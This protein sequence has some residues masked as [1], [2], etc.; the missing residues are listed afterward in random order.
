M[1]AGA[2]PQA[3]ALVDVLVDEAQ[4][5]LKGLAGAA[6]AL[7]G[8]LAGLPLHVGCCNAR[9]VEMSQEAEHLL[10]LHMCQ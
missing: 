3:S 1:L 4:G 2:A 6:P 7:D 10:Q 9:C 5:P 8:V